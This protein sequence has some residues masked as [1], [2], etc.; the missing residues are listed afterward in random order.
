MKRLVFLSLLTL[1]SACSHQTQQEVT[2]F[3]PVVGS[4][5]TSP[6]TISG[7]A[8]GTWFFEANII[9]ELTDT[10][11]NQI[12][13]TG[14]SADGE[15]MTTEMVPFSGSLSFITDAE[16]GYLVIRNDNASGLPEHEKTASF[17]VKF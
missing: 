9:A 2:L 8:P 7:E 16:E 15:W 10:E 12:A 14:M 17:A 6:L 11:G 4:T 5:V 1:L 13:I 3:S